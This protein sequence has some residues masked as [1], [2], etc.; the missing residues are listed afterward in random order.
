MI[1]PR[2]AESFSEALR[3]GV[4]TF[5][6]LKEVLSAKGYNTAV[7]DEGGFAPD[8]RSNA[9][10]AE[11]ILV[12]IE[13]AGY[14]AGEDIWLALDPA[15]S[16]FYCD[17][18]HYLLD[19]SKD[20]RKTGQEMIDLYQEWIDRYPIYSIEDG[21]AQDDWDGWR[22]MTQ[23]LGQQVQVVGD[24]LFVTSLK[25]LQKGIDSA[26]ANSILIKLNQIGTLTETLRA[27]ELARANGYTTVISHRSGETED[28][29][30]ADL[31]VGANAGQIKT[32]S[33]SRSDR[34]GKYNQ[35]LRIEEDLGS[36]A[37]YTQLRD[38]PLAA[39]R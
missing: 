25:R 21:L 37:S 39:S 7:G 31:A 3:M 26:V 35:L 10:A 5:H 13:K 18:G 23:A 4:E 24:D 1:M 14:E 36:K 12:A 32:G 30:I 22:A 33:A 19:E 34:V 8:L 38:F 15:A 17:E 9:E 11:L 16:E 20:E 28:S 29:F 2:K 27:I 6:Q